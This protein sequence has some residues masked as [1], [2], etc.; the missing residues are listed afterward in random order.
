MTPYSLN[1][2]SGMTSCPVHKFLYFFDFVAF[3][4]GDLSGADLVLC[5]GM[6]NLS[7]VDGINFDN[8][9]MVSD[10]CEQ[11]NVSY[12]SYNY[13]KN[14]ISEFPISEKYE[15]QTKLV[16]QQSREIISNSDSMVIEKY[17][18]IS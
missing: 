5:T 3:L 10:L 8:V 17:N 1:R 11:F 9:K 18:R 13:N 2:L 16:L 6:K 12:T 7:N 14:L 4:K 15:E